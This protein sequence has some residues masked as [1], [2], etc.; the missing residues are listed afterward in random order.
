MIQGNWVG[1]AV[2]I[3]LFVIVVVFITSRITL[4]DGTIPDMPSGTSLLTALFQNLIP[5][6]LQS[7]FN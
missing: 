1:I 3:A 7:I 5:S 4:A 6:W 2:T